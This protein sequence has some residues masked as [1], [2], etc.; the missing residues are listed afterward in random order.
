VRVRDEAMTPQVRGRDLDLRL[1][2]VECHEERRPIEIRLI[3]QIRIGEAEATR[4][5]G[6]W[7]KVRDRAAYGTAA[8]E[9]NQT[10]FASSDV[11]AIDCCLSA[12]KIPE[13]EAYRADVVPM[14]KRRPKHLCSTDTCSQN[15]TQ[16]YGTVS[17]DGLLHRS[18]A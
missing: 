3:E 6:Q 10:E 4:Q 1:T 9:M 15:G 8:D 7:H 14:A 12:S 13:R 2:Y 17:R 16:H 5:A 18:A 11:R